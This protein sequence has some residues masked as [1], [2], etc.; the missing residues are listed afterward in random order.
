MLVRRQVVAQTEEQRAIEAV[1]GE[2]EAVSPIGL[3]AEVPDGEHLHFDGSSPGVQSSY[4]PGLM[5]Y[6]EQPHTDPFV[7]DMDRLRAG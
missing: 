5:L 7:Q 2:Y 3:E 6:A 1:G 4:P